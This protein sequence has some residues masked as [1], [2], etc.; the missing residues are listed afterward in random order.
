[1]QKENPLDLVGLVIA[2]FAS[3]TSRETAHAV[4][5]YVAIIM[6]SLAGSI[7]RVCSIETET[8]LDGF[9]ELFGRAF[10]AVSVT[11][12]VAMLLE[13]FFPALQA[14]YT[15]S[16]IAFMIGYVKDYTSILDMVI[17]R[18]KKLGGQT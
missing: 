1:M 11:V 7:A 15:I 18:L 13:H 5:P 3:V 6:L 12:S 14:R 2:V 10:V 16:P 8:R 4:G 17:K 9:R